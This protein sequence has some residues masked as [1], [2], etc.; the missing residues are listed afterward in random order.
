MKTLFTKLHIPNDFFV[1]VVVNVSARG[2][3]T[4]DKSCQVEE[5]NTATK[6]VIVVNIFGLNILILAFLLCALCICSF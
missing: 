1:V 3:K 6:L 2:G 5:A 4:T